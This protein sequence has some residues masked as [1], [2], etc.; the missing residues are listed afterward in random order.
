MSSKA[1][2]HPKQVSMCS[3]IAR[4]SLWKCRPLNPLYRGSGHVNQDLTRKSL[5]LRYE[6]ESV[7]YIAPPK[8]TKSGKRLAKDPQRPKK[9]KTAYLFY[10]D[11]ASAACH[12]AAAVNPLCPSCGSW[13][14][15]AT[16]VVSRSSS[17]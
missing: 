12:S 15:H 5:Q 14:D 3:A 7:G 16:D 13:T 2:Q 4:A 10:A 6:T 17:H 1:I 11:Q 8:P 9:A